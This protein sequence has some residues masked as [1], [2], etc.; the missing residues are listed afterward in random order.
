M[1]MY[2]VYD[3]VAEKFMGM[4]ESINN[5][6]ATR[7][8]YAACKTGQMAQAPEDYQLYKIGQFDEN[9]GT[10]TNTL[11]KICTGKPNNDSEGDN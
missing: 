10:F 2:S 1:N 3:R 5:G 9:K 6:T 8:F 4:F 7:A 11:R